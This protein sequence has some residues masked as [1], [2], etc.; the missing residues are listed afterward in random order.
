[1]IPFFRY[2]RPIWNLNLNQKSNNLFK[3]NDFPTELSPFIDKNIDCFSIPTNSIFCPIHDAICIFNV[4]LE[5]SCIKIKI[6]NYALF[7]NLFKKCSFFLIIDSI[8]TLSILSIQN[9]LSY[10]YIILSL[11]IVTSIKKRVFNKKP[12]I[13]MS[14]FLLKKGLVI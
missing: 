1:M 5:P 7:K 13:F 6:I 3:L 11:F 10:L 14:G 4:R 12:D 2:T 8:W 9:F